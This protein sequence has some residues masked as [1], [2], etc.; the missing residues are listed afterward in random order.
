MALAHGCWPETPFSPPH[1]LL[2]GDAPHVNFLS[3]ASQ[4]GENNWEVGGLF[5]VQS[6][7]SHTVASALFYSLEMRKIKEYGDLS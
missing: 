3:K 6:P 5:I 7:K 1:E 4:D 2:R